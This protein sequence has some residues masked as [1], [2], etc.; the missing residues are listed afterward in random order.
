M[1]GT[2]MSFWEVMIYEYSYV[3]DCIIKIVMAILSV[4]VSVVVV[5]WLKNTAVPWMKEKRLYTICSRFVKAAEKM[6]ESGAIEK[7]EKK[8]F[9]IAALKSKGIDITGEVTSYIE[10]AVKELDIAIHDSFK[11]MVDAFNESGSKHIVQEDGASVAL[12]G[13]KETEE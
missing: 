4:V 5:P 7:D 1:G 2:E 3:V 10:S 9:V 13:A 11:K 8:D 12:Y 6:A